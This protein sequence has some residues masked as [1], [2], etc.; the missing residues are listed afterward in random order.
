MH[1]TMVAGESREPG[2]QQLLELAKYFGVKNPTVLI[3]EVK[4]VIS[5]WNKYAD[6]CGVETS[7]RKLIGKVLNQNL[8]R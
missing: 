2:K 7:S 1:S 5:S 8:K 3:Q 6:D 4:D